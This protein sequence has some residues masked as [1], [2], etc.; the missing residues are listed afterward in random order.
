MQESQNISP[1][2]FPDVKRYMEQ[3]SYLNFPPKNMALYFPLF[4][5]QKQQ[6]DDTSHLFFPESAFFSIP[7]KGNSFTSNICFYGVVDN[8]H[9]V[10][11]CSAT[12]ASYKTTKAQPEDPFS[13][14]SST[15][16]FTSKFTSTS[17]STSGRSIPFPRN[18]IISP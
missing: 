14:S 13:V 4:Q 17:A 7:P 12:I 9:I 8:H 18:S 5:S 15:V 1:V 3:Q 10:S 11:K 6:F 16:S 2:L